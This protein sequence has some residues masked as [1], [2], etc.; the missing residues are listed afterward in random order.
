MSPT[1]PAGTAGVPRESWGSLHPAWPSPPSPQPQHRA[2]GAEGA[3]GP[4]GALALARGAWR[5]RTHPSCPWSWHPRR[6][7]AWL[8]GS[9]RSPAWQPGGT[10]SRPRGCQT[11]I[12]PKSPQIPGPSPWCPG[13][14]RGFALRV[15]LGGDQALADEQ[16]RH[17]PGIVVVHGLQEL[18]VVLGPVLALQRSP[19]WALAGPGF[20][21]DTVLPERPRPGVFSCHPSDPDTNR[22][23]H[24]WVP[25][26]HP[27]PA[28]PAGLPDGEGGKLGRAGLAVSSGPPGWLL[29]TPLL[30]RTGARRGLVAPWGLGALCVPPD[31]EESPQRGRSSVGSPGLAPQPVTTAQGSAAAGE[32][33]N[34]RWMSPP[35]SPPGAARVL[36]LEGPCATA[37]P[38]TLC[39]Q[40]TLWDA[41]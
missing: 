5:L 18:L 8:P 32:E 36:P 41:G 14:L 11:Q 3:E 13:A 7:P 25:E 9:P 21:K 16:R 35:M 10:C 40:G 19:R 37:S 31:P 4:E 30:S 2:E 1:A 20:G 17:P 34:G 15:Q 38:L 24:P 29:L 12:E 22:S 27:C 26:P 6:G 39:G 33:G 23:Q 28:L